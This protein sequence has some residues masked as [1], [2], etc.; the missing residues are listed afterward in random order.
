MFQN[1]HEH[2]TPGE[3][4]RRERIATLKASRGRGTMMEPKTH[5]KSRLW[6]DDSLLV[7]ER[8]SML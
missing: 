3:K 5:V 6:D 8:E 2:H 7:Y 4:P 1:R